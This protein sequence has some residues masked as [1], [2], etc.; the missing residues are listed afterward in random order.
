VPVY[1][2]PFRLIQE[3]LLEGT[4]PAQAALRDQQ[5]LTL[6]GLV[7][8]QACDDKVCFN[9]ATVPVTWTLP[10]RQL[11]RERPTAPAP[12]APR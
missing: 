12:P 2:K 6:T 3:V 4:T 7:E 11:V 5:S 1:Q 9:P 10:L 8:Y